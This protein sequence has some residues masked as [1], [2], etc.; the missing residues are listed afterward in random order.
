MFVVHCW[1]IN[2]KH[3]WKN[4]WKQKPNSKH[5]GS[6]NR[7]PADFFFFTS[8]WVAC[9]QRGCRICAQTHDQGHR[10]PPRIVWT[11]CR[12]PKLP[13]E[14][15]RGYIPAAWCQCQQGWNGLK[16]QQCW[17][18]RKLPT[19][20]ATRCGMIDAWIF[21][22]WYAEV[23]LWFQMNRCRDECRLAF[24]STKNEASQEDNVRASKWAGVD[25]SLC[26]M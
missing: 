22:R 2:M 17:L 13:L 26:R 24:H 20:V 7:K 4:P 25:F 10:S 11:C 8:N 6:E 23:F 14:N 3:A 21:Q 9:L 1:N 18:S 19:A 16:L 5:H 12:C 15:A